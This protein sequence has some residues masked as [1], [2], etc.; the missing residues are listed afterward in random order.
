MFG[1]PI[2]SIV[3][4]YLHCRIFDIENGPYR[5]SCIYRFLPIFGILMTLARFS[6][7]L[8]QFWCLEFFG[9]YLVV[10]ICAFLY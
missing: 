6:T 8:S 10:V 4:Q 9:R 3:I 2:S 7:E 1:N 5:S